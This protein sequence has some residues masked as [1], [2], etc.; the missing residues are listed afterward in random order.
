MNVLGSLIDFAVVTRLCLYVGESD[1]Y[2]WWVGVGGLL[3]VLLLQWA[4]VAAT[5]ESFNNFVMNM[6][7]IFSFWLGI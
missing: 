3:R 2:C 1:A 7:P 5:A 4:R 6:P